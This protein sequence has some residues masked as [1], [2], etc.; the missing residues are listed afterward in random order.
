M[1]AKDHIRVTQKAIQVFQ[2]TDP[3]PVQ[4]MAEY[5][6]DVQMGAHDEDSTPLAD[7]VKH[8]HFFNSDHNPHFVTGEL[9]LFGTTWPTSETIL[10]KRICDFEAYAQG[11]DLE[12]TSLA[13]GRI[14]HHIQDMSTPSHV[15]PVYHGPDI[16]I[17]GDDVLIGHMIK[18]SFEGY[19]N[20]HTRKLID[21]IPLNDPEYL[22]ALN[23]P[24]GSFQEIYK[25][26]ALQTLSW[27]SGPESRF[28]C[29]VDGS[30]ETLG[31][32]VFWQNGSPCAAEPGQHQLMG[33][34]GKFGPLGSF[35]V[36]RVSRREVNPTRLMSPSTWGSSSGP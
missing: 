28:E 22:S 35:S 21:Q 33:G 32:D 36:K 10:S 23:S 4:K 7:R 18:D 34:F 11:D 29:S 1:K 15:V 30:S 9:P 19:A 12:R 3:H 31:M 6:H 26:G 16:V 14:L 20:K 17:S 24:S 2:Y 5:S 8:W 25:D 27:L 13:L